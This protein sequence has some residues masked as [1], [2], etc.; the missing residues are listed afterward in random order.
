MPL[1]APPFWND[2]TKTPPMI[3][4]VAAGLYRYVRAVHVAITH[5]TPAKI[6]TICVG[7]VTAGGAGKTPIVTALYALFAD[8][9]PT[10]LLRG[11]G[12]T[13]NGP[14]IVT[15]TDSPRTVGDEA[16]LHV[17]TCPAVIAKNRR[18]GIDF[19]AAQNPRPRMII[20]DDGLQNRQIIPT[21]NVMVIDGSVGFGN[22]HLI[23]AG[24]LREPLPTALSRTHLVVIIGNDITGVRNIIAQHTPHMTITTAYIEPDIK[25]INKNIA[26]IAVAG[27]GRPQKFFDTLNTLDL[28]IVAT[29]SFSD[30]FGYQKPDVNALF[31]AAR[32]HHARIITTEKDAVKIRALT[33]QEFSVLPIRAVFDDP[34]T[35]RETINAH[36]QKSHPS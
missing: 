9:T 6:P 33:D 26:Y 16:I 4:R 19:I 35:V 20:M 8:H 10:I 7:N 18:D 25:N 1:T 21:I 17:Q 36:L 30:H 34:T 13:M 28:T 27:I 11:Y 3:Y 29:K 24:P 5:P 31:D 22:A 14:H 2:P 32:M 12:G 15:A 23:P